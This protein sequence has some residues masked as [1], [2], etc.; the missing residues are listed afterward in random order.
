MAAM[1]TSDVEAT[2][3][4]HDETPR[5]KPYKKHNICCDNVFINYK[6]ATRRLQEIY[7]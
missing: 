5:K 2:L 3:A 1:R 4:L 7:M 6:I